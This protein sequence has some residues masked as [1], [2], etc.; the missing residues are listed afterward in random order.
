MTFECKFS[1]LTI[2]LL[3]HMAFACA[4]ATAAAATITT[5]TTVLIL[6]LQPLQLTYSVYCPSNDPA[7]QLLSWQIWCRHSKL[8]D[9]QFHVRRT[10]TH[11]CT[12]R[13]IEKYKSIDRQINTSRRTDRQT[14]RYTDMDR[15]TETNIEIQTKRNK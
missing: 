13:E 7:V 14:D 2:T 9:Q 12:D 15:K 5:T 8:S 3:S 10:S 11:G 1:V 4:S 6:L